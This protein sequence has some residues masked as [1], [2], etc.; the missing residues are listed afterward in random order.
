M[1]KLTKVA[2][3]AILPVRATHLSAGVD[4]FFPHDISILPGETVRAD[5]LI[6][7]LLPPQHFGLLMMRSGTGLRQTAILL[8]QV[9]GESKDE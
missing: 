4:M 1:F 8:G 9:I 5:L 6:R 3:E 2:R 7:A